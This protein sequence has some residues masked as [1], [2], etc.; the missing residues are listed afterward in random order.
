MDSI[1]KNI[2][3]KILL[4]IVTLYSLVGFVVLPYLMQSNF[5]TLVKKELNT[6]A[7]LNRV[8]INPF[9]FS[10]E[11]HNLLIQDK[12]ND[13]LLYVESI[14]TDVE[15]LELLFGEIT[16][17][18]IYID[19]LNTSISLYKENEFNFSHILNQLK[20]EK[21][22]TI[23]QTDEI[24]KEPLPFSI[25]T[26]KLENTILEF[27]DFTKSNKFNIKTKPFDLKIDNFSTKKNIKAIV[28][29]DIEIIDTLKL[30]LDSRLIMNPM[31]TEGD[32]SFTKFHLS[33]I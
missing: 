9:T 32:I 10:I 28:R 5:S 12:K 25:H 4:I 27:T 33:K 1:F 3:I 8:Y 16:L 29:T 7:Y 2:Y 24:K 6:N 11:L 15:P 18:Y 26:F 17:D 23:P 22:N 20:Q 19:S 21:T 31:K 13:L 14:K 30:K